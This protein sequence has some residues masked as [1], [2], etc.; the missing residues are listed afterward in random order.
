MQVDRTS[1]STISISELSLRL[2]NK[3][4]CV[5]QQKIIISMSHVNEA[6]RFTGGD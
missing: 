5:V 2:R 6:P 3:L 4:H 1:T